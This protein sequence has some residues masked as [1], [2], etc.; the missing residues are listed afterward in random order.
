MLKNHLCYCWVF[1]TRWPPRTTN[2]CFCFM[3]S[4]MPVKLSSKNGKC[5]T[6][7]ISQWRTIIMSSYC[8]SSPTWVVTA[9]K[10]A[11]KFVIHGL[12]LLICDNL[13]V[14]EK[15]SSLPS[16]AYPFFTLIFFLPTQFLLLLHIMC[17]LLVSYAPLLTML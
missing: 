1:V 2:V 7:T 17:A 16:P 5:W 4:I 15:V 11:T 12:R 14:F 6:P 8:T 3:H 13:M 10:N 9:P